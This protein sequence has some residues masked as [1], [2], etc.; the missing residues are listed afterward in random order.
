[1][2]ALAG[3]FRSQ[4]L[5]WDVLGFLF[6]L[7]LL[8]AAEL[9][10]CAGVAQSI[11][12]INLIST[13][14]EVEMGAKFATE[15]EKELEVLDDAEITSYV[16]SICQDLA[17]HSKRQD[18]EY[19]TKVIRSEE[20]N[21][22]AVMGGYLYFNVGLLRAAGTEAELA[23]VIGHEIGHIVGR[24]S[25]KH[26]SKQ[27]GIAMIA[28]LLLGENPAMWESLVANVLA[29]GAMMHYSREAEREA[30]GY[31]IEEM[32]GAGYHPG[33]LV[34]FFE[35]IRELEKRSPSSVERFFATHPPTEER[36]ETALSNIRQM[37]DLSSLR[38]DT[39][40]FHR[41]QGLLP[42][43]PAEPPGGEEQG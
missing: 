15:I 21:A 24:H 11:G 2:R 36:L 42:E 29:L 43:A 16:D 3:P 17:R 37:S 19:R 12:E 28:Q 18:I 9:T 5:R 14:E 33:G 20:I 27:L 22:F 35:K 40:E 41:I 34:T 38:Q 6:I 32:V 31:A 7:A 8:A 1:M 13:R 25:A 26:F 10:G 39:P 23:G 30:D 4:I